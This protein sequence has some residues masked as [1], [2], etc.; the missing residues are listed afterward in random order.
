ML[1]DF[2]L[3]DEKLLNEY[4][5]FNIIGSKPSVNDVYNELL[6]KIGDDNE[7]FNIKLLDYI[8]NT[9]EKSNLDYSTYINNLYKYY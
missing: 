6:S 1:K 5:I 2:L 7:E 8:S 4:F 3:N 9:Y